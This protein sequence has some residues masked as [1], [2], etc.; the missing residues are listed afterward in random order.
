VLYVAILP[1]ILIK[2]FGGV[3]AIFL[4]IFSLVLWKYNSQIAVRLKTLN[5]PLRKVSRGSG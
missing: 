1:H 4:M 3:T 5:R 2:G